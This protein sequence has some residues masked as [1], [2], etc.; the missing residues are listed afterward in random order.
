MIKP[1]TLK[2][3][4]EL[5]MSGFELIGGI[6]EAGRGAWAGPVVAAVVVLPKN[7]R[8]IS[9]VHDSKL[10]KAEER[11]KIYEKITER[12]LDFG[13][14]VVSH[15]VINEVGILEATK[16]AAYEAIQML[17]IKPDYLL[18]DYLKMEKYTDIPHDA[19]VD[20]DAK[21]YSISCASIIAKVTRDNIMK[22]LGGLYKQYEFGRHKGYG[23]KK[24]QELLKIFGPSDIHRKNYEPI[25][26]FRYE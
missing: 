2:R 20:G 25:R 1:P 4:K 11:S 13:I 24:H 14:G 7:H 22:S 8:R 9:G 19:I 15:E 5:W 26:E 6:D 18:T 10:V 17:E 21:V 12:A 3:E 23:T 16:Q